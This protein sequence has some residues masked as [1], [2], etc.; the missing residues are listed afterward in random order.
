MDHSAYWRSLSPSRH[1][2][3]VFGT[4]RAAGC[5]TSQIKKLRATL[6]ATFATAVDDGL[7]RANPCRGVRIPAEQDDGEPEEERAKALTRVEVRK[8]FYRASAAG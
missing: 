7:L 3:T 2:E 8:Q 5:S 4:L 1:G 6:S